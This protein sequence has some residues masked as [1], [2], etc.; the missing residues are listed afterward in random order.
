MI[1]DGFCCN[2]W[3]R[4]TSKSMQSGAHVATYT[5]KYGDKLKRIDSMFPRRFRVTSGLSLNHGYTGHKWDAAASLY[6]APYRYYSPGNAR[7]MTRDPLGMV[8]GPNVYGYTNNNPINNVDLLGGSATLVCGGVGAIAGPPGVAVGA[9]TG[10]IIDAAV[11][12]GSAIL[13]AV[14]I[15]EMGKRTSRREMAHD[16]GGK[17]L[18]WTS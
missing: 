14:V 3:G 15:V 13:T 4:T 10:A 9:G 7:W 12:V 1:I 16:T 17:E 8:D 2:N 18:A 5:Y 11:F 6:Y